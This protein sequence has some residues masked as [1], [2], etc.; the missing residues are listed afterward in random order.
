MA[1]REYCSTERICLDLAIDRQVEAMSIEKLVADRTARPAA[2]QSQKEEP[3][4]GGEVW[5]R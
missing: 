4:L 1:D 3:I 2:H 5:V